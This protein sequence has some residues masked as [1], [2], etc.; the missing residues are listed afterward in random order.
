M[1]NNRFV[2]SIAAILA[3]AFMLASLPRCFADSWMVMGE[4]AANSSNSTRCSARPRRYIDR[5]HS[6]SNGRSDKRTRVNLAVAH[7]NRLL[8]RRNGR[9]AIQRLPVDRCRTIALER[10][11]PERQG[12]ACGGNLGQGDYETRLLYLAGKTHY[13][14]SSGFTVGYNNSRR[15]SLSTRPNGT[16]HS[17]GWSPKSAECRESATN[18]TRPYISV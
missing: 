4:A 12:P 14:K 10:G 6:Y 15:A 9:I 2:A 16:K 18:T 1:P 5:W 13:W 17:R 3:V 7:Y 11:I 8:W